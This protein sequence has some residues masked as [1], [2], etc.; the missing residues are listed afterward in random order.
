MQV[1]TEAFHLA[2]TDDLPEDH[3]FKLDKTL[4]WHAVMQR[5]E[6]LTGIPA[7]QQVYFLFVQQ[8]QQ[9]RPAIPLF[10]Q[11]TFP[12]NIRMHSLQVHHF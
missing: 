11:V 3:T 5:I 9:H 12:L 4:T 6:E 1:E 7:A 2:N 8:G 10:P